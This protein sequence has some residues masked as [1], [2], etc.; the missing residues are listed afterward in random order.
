M[1]QGVAVGKL[2]I[3]EQLVVLVSSARGNVRTGTL[4]SDFC[5]RREGLSMAGHVL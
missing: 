2:V 5:L 4:K 3:A 1:H